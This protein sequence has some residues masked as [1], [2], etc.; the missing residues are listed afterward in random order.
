MGFMKRAVLKVR[1]YPTENPTHYVIDYRI[2]GKRKREF[3]KT[4]A[5]GKKAL[6]RIRQKIDRGGKDALR[7]DDSL[8]LQAFEGAEALKPFGKTVADAVKFY[9][10]HLQASQRSIT[11]AE[12]V[13]RYLQSKSDKS[14]VHQKD[15]ANRCRRFALDFGDRLCHTVTATEIRDWITDLE[16][17][18]QSFNN[19]RDRLSYLFSYAAENQ[20]LE[21]NPINKRFKR[22]TV[23]DE[24]PEIYSVDE[25]TRVLAAATPELVPIVAIGAFAGIRCA[26]LM[27]LEWKDVNFVTGFV[28][29]RGRIAKSRAHR[30]IE[31]TPNLRA[32]L[33]PYVGRTGR[34]WHKTDNVFHHQMRPVCRAA[35]MVQPPKNGLRHSYASY[36]LKAFENENMLRLN[37]GHVGSDLI[38]SNY[39]ALCSKEEAKRFWEIRPAGVA[40]NV[41]SMTA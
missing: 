25:L 14:P 22:Q 28:H 33:A 30:S 16:L 18:P 29:V 20:Y 1:P 36:F 7:L 5:E 15:L 8:R 37:L 19:W 12:L 40:E 2:A 13:E 11:V 35:G 21:S 6:S 41:V 32:W 9:V 4:E 27:R 39:R 26:E 23:D 3:F 38:F 34:I 31:M 10:G 17:G 24:A